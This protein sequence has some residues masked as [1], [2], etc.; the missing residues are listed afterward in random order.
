MIDMT[1]EQ[2]RAFL[3]EGTRTGKLAT[4]RPDG[5]PHVTPIW[6]IMD[7]EKFVFNTWHKSVKAANLSHDNRVTLCVDEETPPFS[8][9]IIE[10]IAQVEPEPDLDELHHWATEIAR[11]YMGEDQAEAFGERNGVAG[12]W[13]IRIEPT[14]I[15]AKTN[16]S[17]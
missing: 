3:L 11:R 1:P 6:F 7:G 9:V 14:K 17:D 8:F 2:R 16:V 5:R 4:V 12:E 10:G 13:L 15:I